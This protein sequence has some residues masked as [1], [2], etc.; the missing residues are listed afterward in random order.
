M[1]DVAAGNRDFDFTLE[2]TGIALDGRY[3]VES[4]IGRGSMGARYPARTRSEE[5]WA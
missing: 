4:V 1:P 3:R 2:P 5:A